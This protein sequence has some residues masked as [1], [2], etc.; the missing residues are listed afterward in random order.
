MKTKISHCIQRGAA[1][2]AANQNSDGSFTSYIDTEDGAFR[3]INPVVTVFNPCLILSS[4][5]SVPELRDHACYTALKDFIASQKN[6]DYTYNYW[7]IKSTH[8]TTNYCPD[9][10]DDTFCAYNALLSADSN[11][12][13]P[14][15]LVAITKILIATEASIG[16]PYRTWIVSTESEDVWLDVDPA[17]NAN[18]AYFLS[19]VASIPKGLQS[20]LEKILRTNTLQS[21]YYFDNLATLYY[22]SRCPDKIFRERCAELLPIVDED[23]SSLNIALSINILLNAGQEDECEKY[24]QLLLRKQHLDGSWPA[25]GFS[26]DRVEGS[27][28]YY[29]GCSTLTT[30][31]ALEALARYREHTVCTTEQD[32][33]NNLSTK[34][35]LDRIQ[36][37]SDSLPEELKQTMNQ[38]LQKT[39]TGINGSEILKNATMLNN[40][41]R[42]PIKN[43]DEV[44][45]TLGTANLYGWIAY[46]IYDDFIDNEGD[47]LL[48]PTANA[49]HR[50][51]L[52]SFLE[53]SPNEAFDTYVAK[54]F[55]TMDAANMWELLHCRASVSDRMITLEGLPD[56]GT[57]DVLAHR[58]IGHALP[59]LT[60]LAKIGTSTESH[61]FKMIEAAF[62]HYLIAKQLN[63][64][65]HD[66]LEDFNNGHI[67]Y[68]V[69]AI[70]REMG[71]PE[72]V[73]TKNE[74]GPEMQRFFWHHTVLTICDQI[75]NQISAG[76]AKLKSST[77]VHDNSEMYILFKKL[78]DIVSKT[79]AQRSATLEFLRFYK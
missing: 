75:D 4:L 79:R 64:D 8:R 39:Q 42:D 73:H 50:I 44:F 14:D 24:I 15:I 62:R 61:E 51:S 70:L 31:F 33:K 10:I 43:D 72:G 7:P 41:L 58:S 1:Y 5:S 13:T 2:I 30:A 77:L 59:P 34:K 46:T 20:Y 17:V 6:S 35:L 25:A 54:I 57:L 9:D 29:S 18:V 36:K 56:Y 28:S 52:Y 71:V 23:T 53:A 48:L 55:N 69:A 32:Q 37:S 12:I 27:S 38:Y 63:D 16:G 3:E 66:W 49:A 74:L 67:S 68:V 21:A 19:T 26:I 47:P 60:L 40:S 65:A 76:Q 45:H 78:S 22:L 11:S